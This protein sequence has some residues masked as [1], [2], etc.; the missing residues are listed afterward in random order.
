MRDDDLWKGDKFKLNSEE[1][2]VWK[3]NNLDKHGDS[4]VKG[5]T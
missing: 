4:I 2:N 3:E 5:I 1:K